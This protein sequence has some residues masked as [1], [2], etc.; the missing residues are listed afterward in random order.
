MGRAHGRISKREA[1]ASLKSKPSRTG[2]PSDPRVSGQVPCSPVSKPS[3]PP[4]AAAVAAA[5]PLLRQGLPLLTRFALTLPPNRFLFIR[6][7]SRAPAAAPAS[8]EELRG[9]RLGF[10]CTRSTHVLV[11]VVWPDSWMRLRMGVWIDLCAP[12]WGLVV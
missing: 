6:T 4:P 12:V 10:E 9:G 8:G 1:A 11:R 2:T 5:G 7:R 3:P